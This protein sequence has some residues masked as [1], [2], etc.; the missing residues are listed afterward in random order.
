MIEILQAAIAEDQHQIAALEIKLEK[1]RKALGGIVEASLSHLD[2]RDLFEELH[3]R[4]S[5]DIVRRL[6]GEETRFEADWLSNLWLEIQRAQKTL[7]EIKL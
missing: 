1:A 2:G 7:E 5:L 6:D 3:P 4:K